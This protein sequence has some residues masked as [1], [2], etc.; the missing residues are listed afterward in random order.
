MDLSN[1]I[2]LIVDSIHKTVL[3]D[4]ISLPD[5]EALIDDAFIRIG[6][7][8][9][10]QLTDISGAM[11]TAKAGLPGLHSAIMSQRMAEGPMQWDAE[12]LG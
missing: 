8:Y 7:K 6:Q 10:G 3:R 12:G 4:G 2:G 5:T 9:T 1:D 11:K